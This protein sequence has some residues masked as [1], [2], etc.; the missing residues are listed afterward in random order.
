MTADHDLAAAR[1]IEELAA[2]QDPP[3]DLHAAR[4][5]LRR[6]T[7]R[8]VL[9]RRLALVAVVATAAVLSVAIFRGL[10]EPETAPLPARYLRS[11]LP[12]GTLEGRVQYDA[13]A[14]R[15]GF[16]TL[17]LIVRANATKWYRQRS[18]ELQDLWPVRYIGAGAGRV[19]LK[20]R[21]WSCS[22]DQNELTLDFI[23]GRDSI[24]ITHA[25]AG[26][27]SAFPDAAIADLR[28][29]I[30]RVRNGRGS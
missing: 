10:P 28:G 24:T 5:E 21:G 25:V 20:G 7:R 26:V 29:V 15:A 27:C 9:R 14:G 22:K 16:G 12:V 18:G 17:R 19:V 3:A 1:V 30:L 6:R 11:G 23:A 2:L 8:V 4:L 13:L